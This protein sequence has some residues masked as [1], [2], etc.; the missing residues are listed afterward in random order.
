MLQQYEEGRSHQF[1]GETSKSIF[2]SQKEH[3]TDY[4]NEKM[5]EHIHIKTHET[6]EYINEEVK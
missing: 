2:E 4:K 3:E 5:A 6:E 1:I